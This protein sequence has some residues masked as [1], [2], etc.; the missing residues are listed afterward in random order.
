MP[1]KQIK[2]P[3]SNSSKT[4]ISGMDMKQMARHKNII[5]W[6][7]ILLHQCSILLKKTLK[8]QKESTRNLPTK[9]LWFDECYN[10]TNCVYI[11]IWGL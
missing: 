8:L 5:S 1:M 6:Q 2:E 11:A 4:E 7:F 10:S 9:E 3:M